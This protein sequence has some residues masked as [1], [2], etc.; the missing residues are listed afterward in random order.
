MC[1]IITVLNKNKANTEKINKILR[2]NNLALCAERSGYSVFRDNYTFD[3]IGDAAYKNAETNFTYKGEEVF[4]IH[5]RTRTSGSM[6]TEGLHLKKL[7]NRYVFAH[8]GIVSAFQNVERF[9][10]SYYFFKRVI[11]KAITVK[12]IVKAIEKYKFSG[13]AFLYDTDKKIMHYFCNSD[14]YIHALP[15]CLIITSYDLNLEYTRY[16][17]FNVL[18][19]TW[20]EKQ[21][22]E[23]IPVLRREKIDD[24]YMKFKDLYLVDSF[25]IGFRSRY[26]YEEDDQTSSDTVVNGQEKFPNFGIVKSSYR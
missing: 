18:G 15:D 12:N 9:N 16:K 23:E 19:Y 21:D 20:Y 1:K 14:S 10:D 25:N 24:M 7:D 17:S 13:R 22:T 11:Q 3:Y 6:D 5:T 2:A 8:N 26:H 4:I